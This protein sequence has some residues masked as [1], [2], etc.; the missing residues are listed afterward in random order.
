M[1][2]IHLR[3]R[4]WR[5]ESAVKVAGDKTL[6]RLFDPSCAER[7]EALCP[8]E[9]Y[10]V[11]PEESPVFSKNAVSPF[12]AWQSSNLALKLSCVGGDEFAAFYGGRISPEHYQ[13]APVARLLQLPRPS[14]LIADDV[15]L[16]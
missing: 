6:F 5:V 10:E 12:E 13:F 16:G 7:L 11:L 8:P 9:K 15:G 1:Q 4:T 3:D 14:L 2:R